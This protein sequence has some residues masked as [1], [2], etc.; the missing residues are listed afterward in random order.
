MK[1]TTALAS[2]ESIIKKKQLSIKI[3]I[4]R[5]EMWLRECKACPACM[6]HLGSIPSATNNTGYGCTC[7]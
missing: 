5:M 6:Q 2:H 3:K 7:L 1:K 4:L